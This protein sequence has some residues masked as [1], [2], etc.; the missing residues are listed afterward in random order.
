MKSSK[1]EVKFTNQFKKIML[2]TIIGIL[3]LTLV[4]TG[5]HSDIL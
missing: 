3:V 1:Y 2:I 5:S 4:R